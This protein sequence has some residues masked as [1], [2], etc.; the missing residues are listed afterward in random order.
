MPLCALCAM[1]AMCAMCDMCDMC[2]MCAVCD[3]QK[4]TA[5]DL[6]TQA[7]TDRVCRVPRSWVA[8]RDLDHT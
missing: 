3:V 6:S 4:N 2:D 5:H 1:C 7:W 8:S